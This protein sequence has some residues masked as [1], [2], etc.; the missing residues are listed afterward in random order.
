MT[1][2]CLNPEHPSGHPLWSDIVG[3]LQLPAHSAPDRLLAKLLDSQEKVSSLDRNVQKVNQMLHEM[4][5]IAVDK[6]STDAILQ[7]C[8]DHDHDLV[9]RGVPAV[10]ECLSRAS[11]GLADCK[12]TAETL[13]HWWVQPAQ[14]LTPWATHTGVTSAQWVEQWRTLAAKF[15]ELQEQ[16]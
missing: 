5:V 8:Q 13:E 7:R 9:G 4:R 3:S 12:K 11:C 14:F 15:S 10:R 16:Q 2:N 6:E 1:I